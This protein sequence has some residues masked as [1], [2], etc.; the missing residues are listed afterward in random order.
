MAD[1]YEQNR[2]TRAAYVKETLGLT[3]K[4]QNAWTYEERNAYLQASATYTIDRPAQFSS[5]DV[6]T[7]R[8]AL[9]LTET[10][11]PLESLSLADKIS[12]FGDEMMNQAQQINPLSE[13][14]R[15]TLANTLIAAVLIGAAAYFAVIAYR[16]TP[17]K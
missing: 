9:H 11:G 15:G 17:A 12:I 1:N 4:P 7:A 14:N 2:A 16:S 10:A 3:D 8:T 13:R 6:A 5:Q